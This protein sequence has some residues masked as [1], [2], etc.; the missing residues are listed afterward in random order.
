MKK[1]IYP[2]MML[3]A[4]GTTACTNTKDDVINDDPSNK[5]AISFVGESRNTPITR[6]GFDDNTQIAMRIKSEAKDK[7]TLYTRII[8]SAAASNADYSSVA[9]DNNYM[10]YWDDAYGRDA[11]LSVYAIAVPGKIGVLNNSEKLENKLVE[12]L[13]TKNTA[14]WFTES[15]DNEKISWKV[16]TTQTST[17]LTDEDLTYSN[18]ISQNG[19]GGAKSYNFKSNA[20]DIVKAG[21]LEFRYKDTTATRD[22]NGPGKF[23]QGHLLFKHALSRIVVNLKK[24]DGFGGNVFNFAENSNITIK[25]VPT[26]G[27]LDIEKGT[28]DT[29]GGSTGISMMA[30]QTTTATDVAHSL[31]AQ[32]LPG[33]VIDNNDT[34]VLEFVIDGNNYSV[35]NAMML[36][37]LNGE[38][39]NATSITMEQGKKYMFDIT[40]KKKTVDVTAS[41][42][43][44]DSIKATEQ[45]LDNSR[46]TMTFYT[47]GV[48]TDAFDLYRLADSDKTSASNWFGNYTD[49][50]SLSANPTDNKWTTNW[51]FENDASYYHFRSVNTGTDIKEDDSTTDD[52]FVIQSGGSD[53]LWGAPIIANSTIAYSTGDGYAS[54]I[55]PAIGST[56]SAINLTKFHMMSNVNVVL[57]TTKTK[58]KVKLEEGS[59]TDLKK[60]KV[61]L[62]NFYAD[63]HVKMGNGLV[64]PVD[65]KLVSVDIA[66]PNAGITDDKDDNSYE[67]TGAFTY[68]VVPQV[69]ART[70]GVNP[71]VGLTIETPDGNKYFIKDMS[72]ITEKVLNGGAIARW[73]PGRSYTY[74]FT[75]TK[76]G[77]SD[78]TASVEDWVKVK[79]EADVTLE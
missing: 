13:Q 33:Y 18:N 54:I 78:I 16:S 68:Y 23:D 31:M 71:K 15:T 76:T 6:A 14:G 12:N 10:R 66:T 7:Q 47:N 11:H 30:N 4:L 36:K 52:Y 39:S 65:D 69:L 53:Y 64:T 8:A 40:V 42:E 32:M 24:G 29:T 75:L 77:I 61:S 62:T 28:W 34:D 26:S 57:R 67:T 72:S 21:R 58:N 5:T 70:T 55:S 43:P 1:F 44:W 38:N 22:P 17:T 79:A 20:Y 27:T 49:K 2:L 59:G 73:L 3:A 60:C 45:N 74:T 37:A 63:G 25:G 50:L 9:I 35:T 19:K 46:S 51:Y 56:S 41:I 48:N